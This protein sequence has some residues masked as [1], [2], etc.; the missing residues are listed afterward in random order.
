MNKFWELFKVRI[1]FYC[2]GPVWVYRKLALITQK[3]KIF[4]K[5]LKIK[6]FFKKVV[7]L[8]PKG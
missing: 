8:L 7:Q 1:I 5:L 2:V 4:I 3:M 6:F